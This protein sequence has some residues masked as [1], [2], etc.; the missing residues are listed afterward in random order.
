MDDV[1]LGEV[2][3]SL[4]AAREDLRSLAADVVGLKV[5]AGAMAVRLGR[6]ES[7][8]YGAVG[9]SAASLLTALTGLL[10]H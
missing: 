8:I 2:A 6:L 10:R 3:R 9:V 4:A 1:T 5:S 7:V